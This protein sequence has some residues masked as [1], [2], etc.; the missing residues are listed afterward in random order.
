[1]TGTRERYTCPACSM[2][3]VRIWA[4]SAARSAGRLDQDLIVDGPDQHGAGPLQGLGETRQGV[5]DDIGGTALD[6]RVVQRRQ[7]WW[8]RP[9]PP[10]ATQGPA[11]RQGHRCADLGLPLGDARIGGKEALMERPGLVRRQGHAVTVPGIGPQ[12]FRA[13]GIDQAKIHGLGGLP[14][15]PGHLVPGLVEEQGSGQ[16][17]EILARLI[18]GQHPGIATEFSHDPQFNLRVIGDDQEGPG[19]RDEAAAE[20]RAPRNLLQVGITTGKPPRRRAELPVGGVDS[21]GRWMDMGR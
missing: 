20:G 14:F 10:A 15:G 8:L 13:H 1:M 3:A 5:F 2:V 17:M 6:G 19:W 16:G 12:S 11:L 18:R 4:T 7:P 21:A 9:L